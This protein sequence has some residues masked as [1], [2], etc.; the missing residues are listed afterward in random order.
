MGSDG[1]TSK[2][3]TYRMNEWIF[4]FILLN[5]WLL[6]VLYDFLRKYRQIIIYAEMIMFTC[7]QQLPYNIWLS[8]IAYQLDMQIIGTFH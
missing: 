2:Y 8:Y 3:N 4:F 7:M 5:N 6:A 1:K